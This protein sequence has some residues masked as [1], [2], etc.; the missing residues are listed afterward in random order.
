[1]DWEPIETIPKDGTEVLAWYPAEEAGD[2]S[3]MEVIKWTEWPRDLGSCMTL[4][5]Q[6]PTHW[7]PLP[8]PPT[9]EDG[10]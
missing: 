9:G 8:A 6:D 4:G 3:F 2:P 10:E 5:G 1:M 7:M